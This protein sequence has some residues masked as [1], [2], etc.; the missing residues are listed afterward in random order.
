M[1]CP[2]CGANLFSDTWYPADTSCPICGLYIPSTKDVALPMDK[3][4]MVGTSKGTGRGGR[5]QMKPCP[6]QGC[7]RTMRLDSA[8]K[9]CAK[10]KEKMARWRKS[11]NRLPMPP[12]VESDGRLIFRELYR[13]ELWG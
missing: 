1:K 10:C 4:K 13:K 3:Q 2:K 11:E 9:M 7:K 8:E 5:V 12:I 6:V